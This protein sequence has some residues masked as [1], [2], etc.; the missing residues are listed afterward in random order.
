MRQFL[1][2]VETY[3]GN[4]NLPTEW[5]LNH[6][7]RMHDL[8]RS[9]SNFPGTVNLGL[10]SLMLARARLRAHSDPILQVNP[11]LHEQ[12]LE[13]DLSAKVPVELLRLAYAQPPSSTSDARPGCR[14]S[15]QPLAATR[16]R[17]RNPRPG[18]LMEAL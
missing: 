2:G 7:P 14:S 13:A 1:G 15:T 11:A 8:A 12:R 9:S 5:I 3:L 16:Q 10:L 18:C 6:A 17:H 4:E